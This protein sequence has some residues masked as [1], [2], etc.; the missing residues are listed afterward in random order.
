ME[1]EEQEEKQTVWSAYHCGSLRVNHRNW[2]PDTTLCIPVRLSCLFTWFDPLG[3]YFRENTRRVWPPVSVPICGE[4]PMSIFTHRSNTSPIVTSSFLHKQLYL[5]IR[6]Q[7]SR[8]NYL[9]E[10]AMLSEI[11]ASC[12]RALIY[13]TISAYLEIYIIYEYLKNVYPQPAWWERWLEG[14]LPEGWFLVGNFSDYP[15]I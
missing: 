15:R 1:R 14:K 5:F 9:Q 13:G 2:P 4:V 7:F 11:F 12:L 8:K 3:S 6:V 10:T